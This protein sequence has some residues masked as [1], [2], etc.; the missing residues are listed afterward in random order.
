[1]LFTLFLEDLF[2][3]Q[4]YTEIEGKKNISAV[5][6][7]DGPAARAPMCDASTAGMDLPGM[8]QCW[9]PFTLAE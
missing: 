1:M 7:P 5:S 4:S 8:P 9:L 3:I 6:S 2:E